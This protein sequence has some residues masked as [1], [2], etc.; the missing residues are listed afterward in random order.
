MTSKDAAME[1]IQR[2]LGIARAALAVGNHG[3]A[4]VCARRAVGEAISWMLSRFPK[5]GWKTDAMSRITSFSGDESFSQGARD[6]ARRLSTRIDEHFRYDVT[7]DPI[8]DAQ[9][10]IGSIIRMMESG[11]C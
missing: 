1:A 3:K 11:D 2:E 4:R 5:A 10:I 7:S 8:S 6:A 9:L